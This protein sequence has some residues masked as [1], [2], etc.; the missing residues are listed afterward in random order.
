VKLRV[1]I[2]EIHQNT[3]F[4]LV[5]LLCLLP[6]SS[7][8]LILNTR[9]RKGKMKADITQSKNLD[10]WSSTLENIFLNIKHVN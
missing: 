1:L 5:E 8:D 4:C 10:L 3:R 2:I 7:E 9:G 6:Y